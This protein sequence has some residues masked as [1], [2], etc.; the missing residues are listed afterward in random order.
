M[1]EDV[2]RAGSGA[3]A[4][5]LSNGYVIMER[6]SASILVTERDVANGMVNVPDGSRIIVV[7]SSPGDYA[8]EFS[9]RA[10]MFRSVRIEGVGRTVEVGG[11]GGTVVSRAAP[12][13]RRVISINYLFFL[14]PDAVPGTYAWPLQLAVRG[15]G[16]SEPDLSGAIAPLATMCGSARP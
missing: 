4:A 3:W 5:G 10:A 15:A 2:P 13:G 11:N 12:S 6:Q 9:A 1:A 16:P 8:V 14:A 7:T